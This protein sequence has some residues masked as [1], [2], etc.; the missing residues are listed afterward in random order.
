MRVMCLAAGA[1]LALSACD[2]GTPPDA[3]ALENLTANTLM[4]NDVVEAG[5]NE[6]ADEPMAAEGSAQP[7]DNVA[8]T[9]AREPDPA[10]PPRAS[11][12]PKPEPVPEPPPAP[13][14]HAGHDMNSM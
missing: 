7:G 14:P 10:T 13:D 3:L 2:D 11:S 12:A 4:V 5:T 9:S 1:A 8:P 6:A